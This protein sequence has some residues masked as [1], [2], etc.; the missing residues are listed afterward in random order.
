M[1]ERMIKKEDGGKE[2]E[3]EE[4]MQGE[5]ERERKRREGER[6]KREERRVLTKGGEPQASMAFSMYFSWFT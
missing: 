4:E 3:R 2:G 6:E 1:E 5:R